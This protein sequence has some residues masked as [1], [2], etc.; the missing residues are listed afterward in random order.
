MR[1]IVQLLLFAFFTEA[2]AQKYELSDTVSAQ[3]QNREKIYIHFDKGGYFPGDTVWFKAYLF[4][5][6][7]PSKISKNFYLELLTPSGATIS[8]FTAPVIE[9]TASGFVV[10][11]SLGTNE[12]F[13]CR[14]YT[15][16]MLNA[17]T[18]FIYKK[19][20]PIYTQEKKPV[21]QSQFQASACFL[22]EGGNLV[23]GLPSV[24]AFKITDNNGLPLESRGTIK[25]QNNKNIVE[26]STAHD[27]MGACTIQPQNNQIYT[28][29]WQTKD[30][31]NYT[32]KLP[33]ALD[34]GIV[35]QI[36]ASNMGKRVVLFRSSQ[37]AEED[38]TLTLI[39]V[40]NSTV[41]YQ[42]IIHMEHEVSAQVS[43]P[44]T[45]LP[46][47]ILYI[48]VFNAKR[49]PLAERITFVNNAN[50]SF[51]LK[52]SLGQLQK[53]KL[54]LN[55]ITL[56]KL[57]SI[58]ANLSLSVTDAYV[59]PIVIKKDD[60]ITHLLLTGDLHGKIYDPS[61]YFQNQE[62]STLR[63][64]D[65]VMLTNGWR[66]YTWSSPTSPIVK[67][68]EAD[69]LNLSGKFKDFGRGN[70][71]R[72]T[73]INAIITPSEG[74]STLLEF[75]PSKDGTF[76]R[77]GVIFYGN[78]SLI[79]KFN[80]NKNT[81]TKASQVEVSNGLL[82]S[83]PFMR[84]GLSNDSEAAV[85]G[86]KAVAEGSTWNAHLN[87]AK[88]HIL[89][90]VVIKGKP[91]TA[92][93]ALDKKY[94]QG[95]FK[96][97][98]SRNIDLG[99]DP[100]SLTY[101]T[102]FQYLQMNIPGLQIAGATSM[103]P[104]VTWRQTPVKFFLNNVESSSADIRAIPMA[105]LDYVK[106]YDPAQGNIFQSEGGTIAVYTKNGKGLRNPTDNS[107]MSTV[108]GYSPIK[109]FYTPETASAVTGVK[110][111]LNNRTTLLW[112]PNIVFAEKAH[113]IQLPFYYNGFSKN[114]KIVLEGISASGKIVHI[115][116][117]F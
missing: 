63:N 111:I 24:L 96:G 14:A 70:I 21:P 31:H 12:A 108:T 34:R 100:K 41:I 82:S 89:N 104:L 40:M 78:A 35:L 16:A 113:T 59:D 84:T 61:Y 60:I 73:K 2:S 74:E 20:I 46:T 45:A 62:D 55:K 99:S 26:F 6:S 28:A 9:S 29:F 91:T 42:S 53:D 77:S 98:I 30:G 51:T 80:A 114:I 90:E 81:V 117:V 11:P 8:R 54:A 112:N 67:L 47:G 36:S 37:L 18:A 49:K 76:S 64:L 23:S 1:F 83:Y 65:L 115:E 68:P 22:P 75:A 19:T 5:D 103:V 88:N 72:D 93:E 58:A 10:L 109:Q 3:V 25:D 92:I 57:D 38:K 107:P 7:R 33:S 56:T 116:Q 15:V 44:T 4:A 86:N 69:Y 17:D 101:L 105:E 66:R 102:F 106:I 39:A 32:T 87:G 95:I 94:T 52:A 48:T 43:I 13:L 97:G 110:E 27:G 85:M 50:Y 71:T 79:F